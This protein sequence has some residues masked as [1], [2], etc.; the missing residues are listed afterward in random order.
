MLTT[1]VFTARAFRLALAFCLAVS[2]ATAAAFGLIYLQVS[3]ADVQRVGAILVD[4]AAKSESDSE[5]A[6]RRA[7]ELRLTRDI[8]RLDYVALFDANGTKLFGDVPAMP[9]IPV[10]GGAHVIRAQALPDASGA[11]PAIF[12]ARRRPDGGVMLLG[13]SLREAYELQE[14]VLRALAIAILP[15]ILLILAIGA[16]FAR[17]ASQRLER[18]HGAIVRI[19][20]GDLDSR[21]PFNEDGDDVDKVARAVNLMLDEIARLLDQLKSTGDNIAHDLRTP[22]AVARAKIERSLDNQ[23]G[24]EQLRETMEAALVQIEKVSMTISAILRI[25]VV[26]H[27]ARETQLT[28]FDLGAVCNQVFDLYE[29]LAESKLIAMDID[30]GKPVPVRGDED[31]MREAISN[32]VD[33]AIKFT[34]P[35]GAVRIEARTVDGNPLAS[36]SDT[37]RGIPSQERARIFRRFYRGER[38]SD[39]TGHGLGLSIAASI[40][41]LHGFELTVE[42]NDPGA[43][44]VMRSPEKA[45]PALGRGQTLTGLRSRARSARLSLNII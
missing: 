25:S 44:F 37:G 21:L 45:S 40:A 2:V 17:R 35:G 24:V 12:V 1:E 10:D 36:V 14:I 19:M 11:E 28:E 30:A 32:L 15:T 26:E 23:V 9:P 31:L 4:E 20:D 18:V 43:R 16:I 33:N 8:R 7:L 5:A 3:S 34:P 39:T 42:D 29:P 38:S 13:R 27:S 22:L 41:R 6:L